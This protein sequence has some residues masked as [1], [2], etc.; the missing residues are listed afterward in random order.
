MR[1]GEE[2]MENKMEYPRPKPAAP[3]TRED[4]ERIAALLNSR[5]T[6][7]QIVPWEETQYAKGAL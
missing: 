4:Y 2:K 6:T 5:L 1:Q 3:P 7:A